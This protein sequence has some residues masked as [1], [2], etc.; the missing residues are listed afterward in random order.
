MRDYDSHR[1]DGSLRARCSIRRA[2][3]RMM[4]PFRDAWMRHDG[5]WHLYTQEWNSEYDVTYMSEVAAIRHCP[6]C[7]E[8]L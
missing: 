4:L 5:M 7:G 6:W 3:H 1:C 2:K 8:E